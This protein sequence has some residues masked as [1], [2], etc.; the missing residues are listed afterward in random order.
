MEMVDGL[1]LKEWIIAEAGEIESKI[2]IID[3]I[4]DIKILHKY[5][6]SY[7]FIMVPKIRTFM[8]KIKTFF[9]RKRKKDR[10]TMDKMQ[11]DIDEKR[12]DIVLK[13]ETDGDGGWTPR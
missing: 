3:N 11:S 7:P 6:F 8:H 2:K 4:N 9:R 1:R 13:K 10:E 12:D 5:D